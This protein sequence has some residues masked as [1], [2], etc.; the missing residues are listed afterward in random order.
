MRIAAIDLGTNTV[1]LLIGEVDHTGVHQVLYADQEVTRLGEGLRP[2]GF[3]RPD[4]IRRT[5]A[6]LRRFR[7]AAAAHGAAQV[8][9]VGTS[10]L[11]EARNREIFVAQAAE[12]AGVAVRVIS[13]EEEALLTLLGV[14]AALPFLAARPFL[15]M[16]IGGGSTEFLLAQAEAIR[17]TVSTGLGVVKLTETHIR[18]DPPSPQELT[19]IRGAATARLRILRERISEVPMIVD[20]GVGTASDAA[21]AMELGADGVLMNT[22]IAEAQD[23]VLMAE[24][25]RDAVQAGRK[26]FLAG[27]IPKKLYESASSPL[28]GVVR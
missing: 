11:R 5:L 23:A 19:A 22:A 1:R 15:L 16:D 8:A 12:E 27:R 17:A 14:R 3:L 18:C 24:A 4:P 20:A 26:A 13:G 2:E 6:T 7:E 10:A 28:S 9:V 25:M 21:V